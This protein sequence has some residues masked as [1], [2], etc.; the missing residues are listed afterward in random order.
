M[1]L[2]NSSKT[3]TEAHVRHQEPK[4]HLKT[5]CLLTRMPYQWKLSWFFE[6]YNHFSVKKSKA[7]LDQHESESQPFLLGFNRTKMC[8]LRDITERRVQ[9]TIPTRHV[10]KSSKHNRTNA[11][12]TGSHHLNVWETIFPGGKH[13]R[14]GYKNRSVSGALN[15]SCK[16]GWG[17]ETAPQLRPE[18][19]FHGNLDENPKNAVGW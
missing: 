11:G 8:F 6:R 15:K 7:N 17:L 14:K 18:S 19:N 1:G 13:R 3:T 4:S 10:C 2:S 16:Q 12:E 5:H 9:S